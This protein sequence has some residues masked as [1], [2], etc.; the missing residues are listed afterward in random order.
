MSEYPQNDIHEWLNVGFIRKT[1]RRYIIVQTIA[2]TLITELI[3][4]LI[5]AYTFNP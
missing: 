1:E 2:I 3:A 5:W 4:L